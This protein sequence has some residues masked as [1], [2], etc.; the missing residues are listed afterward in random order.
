MNTKTDE[1]GEVRNLLLK[2]LHSREEE[3]ELT[4]LRYTTGS[5]L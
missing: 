3:L 5:L 2:R 1:D 4:E